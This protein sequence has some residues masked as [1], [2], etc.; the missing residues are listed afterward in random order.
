MSSF[1]SANGLAAAALVATL[2]IASPALA[3]P[4]CFAAS[5]RAV[6]HAFY[7]TTVMLGLLPL[8]VLGGL[9]I[10]IRSILRRPALQDL[11]KP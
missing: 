3:C 9:A 4:L 6:L 8:G 1:T 5:N 7:L 11:D 2:C 10:F